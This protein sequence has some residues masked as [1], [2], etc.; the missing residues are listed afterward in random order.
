MR[1]LA[2][3]LVVI[4]L[5]VACAQPHRGPKTVAGIGG[6]LAATFGTAAFGCVVPFAAADNGV[7]PSYDLDVCRALAIPAVLGL[8]MFIGGELVW[9]VERDQEAEKTENQAEAQRRRD[10]ITSLVAGAKQ[11]ARAGH[12]DRAVELANQVRALDSAIY[13]NLP[14]IYKQLTVNPDVQRCLPI[15]P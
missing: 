7:G 9:K 14:V 13:V 15:A 12:C 3:S 11:E 4:V 8:A 2:Q 1:T 6:A 5:G 10:I